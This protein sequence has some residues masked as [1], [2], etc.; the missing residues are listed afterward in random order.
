MVLLEIG[1]DLNTFS[2]LQ[3]VVC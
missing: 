3:E 2:Y 1:L